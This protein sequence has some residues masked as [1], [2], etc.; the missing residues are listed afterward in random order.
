MNRNR[1]VNHDGMLC[2]MSLAGQK[3]LPDFVIPALY[4]ICVSDEWPEDE[5]SWAAPPPFDHKES[6]VSLAVHQLAWGGYSSERFKSTQS[7]IMTLL[8]L[9]GTLQNDNR[10]IYLAQLIETVSDCGRS[11]ILP[12]AKIFQLTI[13]GA[14]SS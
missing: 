5:P 9:V 11:E 12:F 3:T 13:L 10:N 4:N 2:L 7:G 6:K 8:G 14:N 1:I